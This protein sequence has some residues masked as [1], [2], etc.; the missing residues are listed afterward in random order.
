[1]IPQK[2]L[3]QF[4]LSF[5]S[6]TSFDCT[7]AY[8]WLPLGNDLNG[9]L[10]Q[11]HTVRLLLLLLLCHLV[12]TIPG[13]QLKADRNTSF[14]LLFHLFMNHQVTLWN[15]TG[16]YTNTK[17]CI[18]RWIRDPVVLLFLKEL[19]LVY[20]IPWPFMLQIKSCELITH[21]HNKQQMLLTCL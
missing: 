1:M 7:L 5:K 8:I 11:E 13:K 16:S 18:L 6:W 20:Y 4:M 19:Y 17:L 21:T 10:F 2:C 12:C 15:K 9:P 14:T 3:I